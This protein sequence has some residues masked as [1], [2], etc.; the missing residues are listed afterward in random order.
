MAVVFQGRLIY[1]VNMLERCHRGNTIFPIL[2]LS[3][4]QHLNHLMT[5]PAKWP[6]CPA[7]T[8]ISKCVR[9]V[10]SVFTV[11]M[12]TPYVLSYLLSTQQRLWS[13]WMDVQADLS[14]RWAHMPFCWFCHEAAHLLTEPISYIVVVEW[15][16]EQQYWQNLKIDSARYT[17]L[18]GL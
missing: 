7:K 15:A 8:Q 12:T 16:N 9:P 4:T 17:V 2:S 10:W 5:K 14:L 13:D 18:F 1:R 6:L 11:H 3:I